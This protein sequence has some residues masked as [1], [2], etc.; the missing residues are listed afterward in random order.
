MHA[1]ATAHATTFAQF[2]CPSFSAM[3]RCAERSPTLLPASGP[4]GGRLGPLF[5]SE[6]CPWLCRRVTSS[7]PVSILCLLRGFPPVWDGATVRSAEAV[8]QLDRT[9]TSV[10]YAVDNMWNCLAG[11]VRQLRQVSLLQGCM[12]PATHGPRELRL[13]LLSSLSTLLRHTQLTHG[14]AA[15]AKARHSPLRARAPGRNTT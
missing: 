7:G 14:L 11:C 2:G 8:T 15:R 5:S 13:E 4:S 10:S 12:A 9:H 6:R 1:R 3:A